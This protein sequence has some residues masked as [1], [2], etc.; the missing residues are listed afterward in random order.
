[1]AIAENALLGPTPPACSADNTLQLSSSSSL[2]CSA[3]QL[4]AVTPKGP[5]QN[6]V[7][8]PVTIKST[9]RMGSKPTCNTFLTG[10]APCNDGYANM[11]TGGQWI[12]EAVGTATPQRFRLRSLVG[13][14]PRGGCAQGAWDDLQE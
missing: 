9:C 3:W 1:M 2:P 4:A 14:G 11:G 13:A 12:I 7:G 5:N 8:V 6:L 10:P